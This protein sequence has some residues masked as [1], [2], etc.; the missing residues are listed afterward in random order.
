VSKGGNYGDA[1]AAPITQALGRFVYPRVNDNPVVDKRLEIFRLPSASRKSD[2]RLRFAQIGT[3]SWYWGVDNIAFYD[4][5]APPQPKLTIAGAQGGNATLY[6]QGNGTLLV[7]AS[8][9]GPWTVAPSQS[10]PQTVSLS[11]AQKFWR[12]GPP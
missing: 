11:G 2:V 6:W 7:A 5:A 4:V 3:A 9:G 1:I 12:I 8:L 10:N